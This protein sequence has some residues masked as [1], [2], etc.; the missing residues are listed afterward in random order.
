MPVMLNGRALPN[1]YACFTVV[2]LVLEEDLQAS[3]ISYLTAIAEK[4][5]YSCP[6]PLLVPFISWRLLHSS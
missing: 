4:K 3:I 1:D 5:I 2:L 6:S